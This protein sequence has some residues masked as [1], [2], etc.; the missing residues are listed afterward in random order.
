M[1]PERMAGLVGRWVRS[2]TRGLPGPAARR[3]I[4]E[5]DADL[6]EHIEHGRENGLSD[7]RIAFAIASRMI[8]GV[9]ADA[10]WRARHATVARRNATEQPKTRTVRRSVV[11]VALGVAVVL[12]LPLVA[13]RVTD[14]VD[15]T[16]ADFA[17]AGTLL[18]VIGVVLEL[19]VRRAANRA[20]AVGVTLFGVVTAV[21]G[22]ADDAPG[23]VLLGLLLTAGGCVLGIRIA[24][25]FN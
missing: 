21:L 18:A 7:R 3:R 8:R 23:L 4:E 17:V 14:Q 24:R 9:A 19:A 13:M 1:K 20:T 12:S 15:W 11:R 5:I 25:R 6:G 22:N 16:W 2:Y 10:A